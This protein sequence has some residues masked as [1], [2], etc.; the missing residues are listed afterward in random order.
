[1]KR[2]LNMIYIKDKITEYNIY[3]YMTNQPTNP[4]L[5]NTLK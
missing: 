1:M 4:T 5:T 3:V 2:K